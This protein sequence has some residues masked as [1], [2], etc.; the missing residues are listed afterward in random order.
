MGLLREEKTYK[1]WVRFSNQAGK[2]SPD[3]RPDIRGA[4]I[5]LLDV[6]P[7]PKLL[8]GAEDAARRTI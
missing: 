4:A 1:A 6:G 3:K 7:E 2:V 8:D 5:K